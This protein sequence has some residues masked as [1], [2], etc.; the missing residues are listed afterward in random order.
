MRLI[1]SQI[2]LQGLTRRVCNLYHNKQS[3]RSDLATC[4]QVAKA[5]ESR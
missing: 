2:K 3:L 5:D 4:L 1:S